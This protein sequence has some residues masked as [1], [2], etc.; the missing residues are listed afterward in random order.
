MTLKLSSGKAR[1]NKTH[2]ALVD[3]MALRN[4]PER[5]NPE[6]NIPESRK[7]PKH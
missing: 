2:L 7:N 6:C 1:I 5:N 3:K 4:C